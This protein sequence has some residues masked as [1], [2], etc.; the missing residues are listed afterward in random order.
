MARDLGQALARTDEYQ[1][2]KRAMSQADDDREIVELRNKIE[3]LERSLQSKIRQ[4]EQPEEEDVDE[5]EELVGELQAKPAYQKLAAAQAN[6]DKVVKKVNE[7]ISKGLDEGADSK[8][9]LPS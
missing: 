6:F 5:Y 7:T 2:L 3:K 9:V 4:G 8:I 1:E